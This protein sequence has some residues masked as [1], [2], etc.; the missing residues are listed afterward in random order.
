MFTEANAGLQSLK[1]ISDFL[2]A[3]KSLRNYNEIVVAVSEV[4]SKLES[5]YNLINQLRDENASLINQLVELREKES[6]QEAFDREF[7]HYS[8]HKLESGSIV[9]RVK[10]EYD[11]EETPTYICADCARKQQ[12]VS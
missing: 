6:R 8:L 10:P 2:K 7:A 9:Y 4:S 11:A 12:I 1:V 3:N 5:A